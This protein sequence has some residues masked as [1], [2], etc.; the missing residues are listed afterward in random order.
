MSR[1]CGEYAEE[2]ARRLR[3]TAS[4]VRGGR[5]RVRRVRRRPVGRPGFERR[6]SPTTST[7]PWSAR[8]RR[9][10]HRR[11]IART[12]RGQHPADRQG[13]DVGGTWYWNR[14]PGIA[15]DV[16][17]YVYPAAEEV[18]YP[19]EKVRQGCRDLRALPADRR[20]LRPLPR[21]LPANRGA[22][23]RW[24]ATRPRWLISTDRGDADPPGS[25]RWPTAISRSPNCPAS[26]ASSFRGC[27]PHQPLGLPLHRRP[28]RAPGRQTGRHHRHR[29]HRRPVRATPG[30]GRQLYVFQRTPSTVDVRNNQPTDAQWA[31]D[32]APSPAGSKIIENFQQLTA[33]G[34]ARR[35]WWPTRDQHR[36]HPGDA[37]RRRE[38][39]DFAKMEEVRA[40]STLVTDLPPPRR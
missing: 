1:R 4:P 5:G 11:P 13:A 31:A 8:V 30:F 35:T 21:R 27:L 18:G 14:Y 20:T 37:G 12:R 24:D 16:E 2:R 6:R 23:I 17:S 34:D 26:P 38:L 10:A 33:G 29:R 3:P 39:A 15:C 28:T 7:W 36:K 32:L 19:D 9:P 25:S 22:E 40:R